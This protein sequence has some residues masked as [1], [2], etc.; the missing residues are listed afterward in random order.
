MGPYCS[1]EHIQP[2]KEK[3]MDKTNI[4]ATSMDNITLV[5]YAKLCAGE[6]LPLLLLPLKRKSEEN[7]WYN[8][9]WYF[10]GGWGG[11]G[12]GGRGWEGV[13]GGG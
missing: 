5:A 9:E 7:I 1:N 3:R 4:Q 13:G 6:L 10:K 12:G 2:R 8:S 11:G